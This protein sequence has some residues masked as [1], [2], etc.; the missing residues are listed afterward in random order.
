MSPMPYH[1]PG[2]IARNMRS[3]SR[4][5]VDFSPVDKRGF[6]LL[7]ACVPL[8]LVVELMTL[9]DRYQ[10][11]ET[12]PVRSGVPA[13]AAKATGADISGNTAVSIAMAASRFSS[14]MCHRA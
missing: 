1:S 9:I 5:S 13:Y 12:A 10:E 3:A 4:Y 6:V 14:N 8:A 7:D 11:K 2:R